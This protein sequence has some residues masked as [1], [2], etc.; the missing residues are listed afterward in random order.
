MVKPSVPRPRSVADLRLYLEHAVSAAELALG[1]EERSPSN[2]TSSVFAA[3][4]DA[5]EAVEE[6]RD[7]F[8]DISSEDQHELLELA[9]R[10]ILLLRWLLYVH[11]VV[12]DPK[13]LST[14]EMSLLSTSDAGEHDP[15]RLN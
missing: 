14:R 13:E 3:L 9:R 2:A 10:A 12:D 15:H 7:A 4:L 11:H 1:G 5:I 8:F 6:S